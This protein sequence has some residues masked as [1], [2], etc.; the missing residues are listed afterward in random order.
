[1]MSEKDVNQ[2]CII[3]Q[4]LIIFAD[5]ILKCYFDKRNMY[6]IMGHIRSE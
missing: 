3:K 4:P 2:S 1:M 5:N 6:V